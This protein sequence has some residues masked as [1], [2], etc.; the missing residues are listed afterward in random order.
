[1][2][3]GTPILARA[4][5]FGRRASAKEES[6][7]ASAPT[8]QYPITKSSLPNAAYN[9]TNEDEAATTFTCYVIG[10]RT[11]VVQDVLRRHGA[12]IMQS[13]GWQALKGRR[14][15]TLRQLLSSIVVDKPLLLWVHVD[16]GKADAQN[17]LQQVS[18]RHL[19]NLIGQQSGGG[20]KV[21]VEGSF[22]EVN[23]TSMGKML[24]G[25][26]AKVTCIHLCGLGIT[27]A[28]D[29]QP[30]HAVHAVLTR[31]TPSIAAMPCNCG[32]RRVEKLDHDHGPQADQ[33][34]VWLLLQLGLVTTPIP[35]TVCDAP[36]R[37]P[38]MLSLEGSCL[39]SV[40]E[41]PGDRT[42]LQGPREQT[43]SGGKLESYSSNPC[44]IST[45][46]AGDSEGKQ[47]SAECSTVAMDRQETTHNVASD[48]IKTEPTT[49][50]VHIHFTSV[51]RMVRV[52]THDGTNIVAMP[53]NSMCDVQQLQHSYPIKSTSAQQVQQSTQTVTSY[54]HSNSQQLAYPT[55][56]RMKEKKKHEMLKALGQD[57][58]L[59][60]QRK[61]ILQ[62]SHYDDCG[63]DFGGITEKK[64]TV[65][66]ADA[67]NYCFDQIYYNSTDSGSSDAEERN[68]NDVLDQAYVLWMGLG[69]EASEDTIKAVPAHA[70]QVQAEK[71]DAFLQKP[72]M[73]GYVDIVEFTGG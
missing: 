17:K 41:C 49:T 23:W 11:A 47:S 43:D 20:R 28:G 59:L 4:Y 14:S 56:Q 9:P 5:D 71:L 72:E 13:H 40:V 68:V 27:H 69:S 70:Y 64:A 6:G 39:P 26:D 57:P 38:V 10:D 37:K 19:A 34:M 67:V 25:N 58:K 16:S 1:M 61:K 35:R 44:Y 36:G 73:A 62:E 55:E 29:G 22:A 12:T 63:S 30:Y 45:G 54:N 24:M 7:S 3:Q 60:R 2:P 52:T 15:S 65:T 48:V 42:A 21:I 32:K 50:G 46:L 33:C 66:F 53:D 31:N 51:N 18:S 8:Y